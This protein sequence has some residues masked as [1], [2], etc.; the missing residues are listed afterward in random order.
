MNAFSKKPMGTAVIVIDVPE[1]VAFE[2]RWQFRAEL[3]FRLSAFAWLATNP[4]E[5]VLIWARVPVER[6]R[7]AEVV[8]PSRRTTVRALGF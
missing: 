5:F 6:P 7:T 4:A 8:I 2:R 3:G 1:A